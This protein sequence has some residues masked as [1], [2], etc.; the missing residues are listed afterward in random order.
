M[1]GFFSRCVLFWGSFVSIVVLS[2]L[3]S[4]RAVERDWT[5][6]EG[7]TA[8]SRAFDRAV[9]FDEP[10]AIDWGLPAQVEPSTDAGTNDASDASETCDFPS[11]P[12]GWTRVSVATNDETNDL[13][14]CSSSVVWEGSTGLV[15]D[16]AS[17]SSC[18]CS[19]DPGKPPSWE[20]IKA[21]ENVR[22]SPG[23]CGSCADP[24]ACGAVDIGRTS[25]AHA[26]KLVQRIDGIDVAT[27][28][29][30]DA[31]GTC[32]QWGSSSGVAVSFAAVPSVAVWVKPGDV[33]PGLCGAPAGGT[34]SLAAPSWGASVR[35]CEGPKEGACDAGGM[36][37][38]IV[39]DDA[40]AE[41][42]SGWDD[43]L[44][45]GSSFVDGRTCT[46]CTCGSTSGST[47][48]THYAFWPGT[49]D[50]A[51]VASV[52]VSRVA[53]VPG[54]WSCVDVPSTAVSG[55]MVGPIGLDWGTCETFGGEPIGEV[56]LAGARVFCCIP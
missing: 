25:T 44:V 49:C 38:C 7:Q 35:A 14:A 18:S 31:I 1:Q 22:A 47:V 3:V 54:D 8:T 55:R 21:H 10:D 37:A 15:W 9:S 33:S 6:G 32:M 36:R 34:A 13:P 56:Q 50:G 24:D 46:A 27:G 51:A 4:C 41:C 12:M 26:S 5:G 11:I 42:P 45:A 40:S 17:C 19:F 29:A 20:P 52:D 30:S 43:R 48:T 23:T 16:A 53:S 2:G 28:D 39:S